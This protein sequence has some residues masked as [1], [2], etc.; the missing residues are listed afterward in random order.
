MRLVVQRGGRSGPQLC[1]LVTDDDLLPRGTRPDLRA[2]WRDRLG[3][4]ARV[5]QSFDASDPALHLVFRSARSQRLD[6]ASGA[7]W[8]AV[9][10]AVMAFDPLSSQGITN[11]LSHGKR[12]AATIAEHLAGNPSTLQSFASQLR[13]EYDH[14]RMVRA[15]YYQIERRWPQAPFWRRRHTL[16]S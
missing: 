6:A 9:G 10:D 7:G 15:G 5:S 16:P 8:L 2:W 13:A 11:A 4:T 14:Y 3:R 12:A 1:M